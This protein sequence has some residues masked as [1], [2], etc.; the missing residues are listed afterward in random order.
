[1]VDLD[2]LDADGLLAP[3]LG[4]Q[5]L[6]GARLVDHVDRLVGQLA[7]VDVARRELHR[8]LDGVVGVRSLWNSSKYGLRPFTIS[9]VSG[10]E[11]S[12][13]S[14]FW[15]RRTRARSFSKYWRYSL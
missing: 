7:V 6:R 1:M 10:I 2:L 3:V 4:Q 15:K 13:T 14:I 9:I 5:H 8:R 11:G 12:L